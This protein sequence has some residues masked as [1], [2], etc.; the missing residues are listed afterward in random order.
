MADPTVVTA[1]PDPDYRQ[2]YYRW[3]REQWAAGAI[4][5]T[6]D[7]R[8]WSDVFTPDQRRAFRW[9][10]SSSSVPADTTEML[11]PFVDA[12]PTEE[13]QVF[14]TTQLAD[15]ARHWVFLERF[16]SEVLADGDEPVEARSGRQNDGWRVLSMEMFLV[17]SDA[18][19]ADLDDMDRLV[20]GIALYH[21][22]IEGAV[23]RT[24]RRFL[25]DHARANDLLPGWCRG[26]IEVA[27]DV[28][29]HVDFATKF[30]RSMIVMD[31]HYADVVAGVFTTARPVIRATFAP[32]DDDPSCFGPLSYGPDDL[33]RGALDAMAKR[34]ELIGL[35]Q[36]P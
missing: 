31:R 4:D 22:V 27:R 14:L 26:S 20:E 7:R 3:E 15:S 11:V 16:A 25:L 18:I 12:A 6:E 28:G 34:A 30:L 1:V 5:L 23:A 36:V 29:R 19:A 33:T 32:P 21:F 13:Q 2:L 9:A 8:Q 10:L 17:A 35:E 24:G